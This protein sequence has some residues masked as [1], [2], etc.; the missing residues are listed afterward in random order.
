[1]FGGRRPRVLLVLGSG[2]GALAAEVADPHILDFEQAGLPRATVPGHAGR[3]I[4]GTLAGVEVLVQQGRLHLY[5]GHSARDVTACVRLAAEAGVETLL[6]TNAA[7]GLRPYQK[8]G[9]LL[10]IADH[11]NLTGTSPLLGQ[12]RFTDMT[13]AYDPQYR[14]LA[15][16]AAASV[17]QRLDEGVYA[18]LAGPA[19]ET[20]AEVRMLRTIGADAVGMSTVLEVIAARDAGLRVLGCSLLTNVH[21]RA[22]AEVDHREVLD[23]AAEAGP[24]LAA[25]VRA[26]LPR[27]VNSSETNPPKPTLQ[28]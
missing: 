14:A 16:E 24:K 17:G 19:Y 21:S 9:D 23:V 8:P 1:M 2:L 18:G 28:D 6:I 5:E 7:G 3:L 22:T 11:L 15:R 20:P 26:V 25:I 10:L 4:A 13:A 27:L 12:P